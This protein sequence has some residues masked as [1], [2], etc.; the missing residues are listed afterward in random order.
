MFVKKAVVKRNYERTIIT[1]QGSKDSIPCLFY[2]ERIFFVNHFLFL[3]KHLNE[4]QNKC[5]KQK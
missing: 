4:G 1:K 5:N 3:V 2:P